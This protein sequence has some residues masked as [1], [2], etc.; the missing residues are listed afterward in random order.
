M[1]VYLVVMSDIKVESPRQTDAVSTDA[2]STDAVSTTNKVKELIADFLS[3][4]TIHGLNHLP[5]AG[6]KFPF[7]R[8][9]WRLLFLFNSVYLIYYIHVNVNKVKAGNTLISSRF[10]HRENLT[11]PAVTLCNVNAMK[12]STLAKHRLAALFLQGKNVSTL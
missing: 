2:V 12:K 11:F 3:G 7:P 10:E 6:S 4:S 5:A 8:Y 9:T 1:L